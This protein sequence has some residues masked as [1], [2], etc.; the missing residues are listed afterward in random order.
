MHV[1]GVGGAQASFR[2]TDGE[3]QREVHSLQ[4]CEQGNAI[5]RYLP[6]GTGRQVVSSQQSKHIYCLLELCSAN[7]VLPSFGFCV[8]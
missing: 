7:G 2:F 1:V 5:Y 4:D 8:F 3:A 6:C